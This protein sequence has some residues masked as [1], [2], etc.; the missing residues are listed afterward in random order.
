MEAALLNHGYRQHEVAVV[1][2][3][4]LLKFVGHDT[5]VLCI[6]THDPLGL[7]PTSTTFS[8]FGGKEPY[9]SFF[10]GN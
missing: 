1:N 8:D 4:S 2:P 7:G 5:K 6:T 9:T 3:E 10:S